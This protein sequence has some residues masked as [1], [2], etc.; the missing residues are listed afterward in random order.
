[1]DNIKALEKL[2]AETFPDIKINKF[3]L[4]GQ[5][6]A[7]TI[8]LANNEIVFKIPLTM[9]GDIGRY[10]KNEAEV[11]RFLEGK[12]DIEIPKVLCTATSEC[13]LFVI[14]ETL[15]PGTPFSYEL[16]DMYNEETRYDIQRQLGKIVRNLHEK[17]GTDVSWQSH[18]YQ[19]THTE[20][21][22]EFYERLYYARAETAPA[23]AAGGCCE[24]ATS[25]LERKK[26][27]VRSLTPEILGVFSASEI[28]AIENIAARYKKVSEQHPVAPVLCHQDLHYYNLMFDEKTRRITGLLDFGC[29][30]YSE[31]AR[32]WHYY[33]DAKYVLEGYG[34]TGDEYFLDRQKFHALSCLLG[35][36]AEDMTDGRELWPL[37]WIREYILDFS[38]N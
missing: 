34:D 12:L 29:A 22:D 20:I 28:T 15:L 17:G 2:V 24:R 26:L 35:N 4:L 5:G 33:F 32:D 14:G 10:Q 16:S 6:K 27:P 21:L 19:E 36:L 9:E 7:A 11:L 13:G 1:V 8:C 37:V 31:P 3:E 23:R 18:S 38:G 30:S 25:D